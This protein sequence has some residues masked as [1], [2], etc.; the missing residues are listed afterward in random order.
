MQGG[1]LQQQ[2]CCAAT[3]KPQHSGPGGE[4]PWLDAGLGGP[5]PSRLA[6]DVVEV[7]AHN[8]LHSVEGQP[9]NLGVL[10]AGG[11]GEHLRAGGPGR[12]RRTR[13]VAH[14]PTRSHW[15]CTWPHSFAQVLH[16]NRGPH[17]PG[18]PLIG[19]MAEQTTCNCPLGAGAH[20]P[21]LPTP[22]TGCPAARC[23]LSRC[24]SCSP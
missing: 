23:L 15:C 18:R 17:G 20:L 4:N 24:T 11:G 10:V 7:L 5:L 22:A 21:L 8:L 6:C 3:T 14:G 19:P 13:S 9:H 12:A 16:M 1:I 2:A